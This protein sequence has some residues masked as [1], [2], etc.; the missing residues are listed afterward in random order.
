MLPMVMLVTLASAE[1]VPFGVRLT[2]PA[3]NWLSA[4]EAPAAWTMV[5]LSSVVPGMVP[6]KVE[7]DSVVVGVAPFKTNWWIPAPVVWPLSPFGQ[8]EPTGTG[9]RK[10]DRDQRAVGIVEALA[11]PTR[12]GDVLSSHRSK[13]FRCPGSSPKS[14]RW[15]YPA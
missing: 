8:I 5:R 2:P 14:P 15:A 9:S 13:S 6:P 7:M 11:H 1:I 4:P 10:R 12:K 3:E